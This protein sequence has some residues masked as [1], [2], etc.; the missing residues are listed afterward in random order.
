MEIV[1]TT[2][3]NFQ[4]HYYQPMFTLIGGG[5]KKLEDS[6]KSMG[7]VLPKN[8][9]WIKDSVQRIEPQGNFVTTQNGMKINYEFLV[10]AAGLKT[11]YTKVRLIFFTV[12]VVLRT[13]LKKLF[14]T[15]ETD[16]RFI[17]CVK[18]TRKWSLFEL[19]AGLRWENVRIVKTIQRRKFNFYSSQHTHQMCRCSPENMLFSRRIF[20]KSIKNLFYVK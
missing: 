2:K 1:K 10:V 5:I 17:R 8:A 15:Y 9:E 3:V 12:A 7:S 13:I 16:T 11:D 20:E 19:F 14:V 18:H 6:R 4:V